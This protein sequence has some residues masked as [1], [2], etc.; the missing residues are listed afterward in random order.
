MGAYDGAEIC[1]LVGLFILNQLYN[2]YGQ[3]NIGLYRDDGLAVFRNIN[4]SQA[5]R[6]RK[7]FH[8]IFK[9]NNLTIEI[10]CNLTKV[11]YLDITFDLSK[12]SYYP[13]RKPNDESNYINRN[14][15]HPESII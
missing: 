11:N 13:Y 7:K 9:N 4:S 12:N 15:N 10:K 14:S 3:S 1:E 6:I 8:K 2:E 5:D